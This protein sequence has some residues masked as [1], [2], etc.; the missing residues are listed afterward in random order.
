MVRQSCQSKAH[1]ARCVTC[2]E[3]RP[4]K[5]TWK[6]DHCGEHVIAGPKFKPAYARIH[7]AAKSSNGLCSNLCQAK[8]DAAVSRQQQFR[9]LIADL[10]AKKREKTRKRKQEA[11]RMKQQ[12]EEALNSVQ[13][14]QKRLRQPKMKDVL[15]ISDGTAADIAVAKWALAHDIPSNALTGPY[16]RQVNLKLSQVGPCY[17]PM[18]RHKLKSLLL[19][20]LKELAHNDRQRN[21]KHQP[22]AGR[23]LTGDG[24]TKGVPLINFLV[25]IPGKGVSLLGVIDC[26]GHISE[27]GIKDALFVLICLSV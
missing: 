16:W 4:D 13:S 7:L 20:A 22:K 24:A 12:D 19:P 14:R 9:K 1:F 5:I 17:T 10:E 3:G 23:T 21:L 2:V 8:D 27:G 25:H 15:K 18:S 6:C 26:T 11:M